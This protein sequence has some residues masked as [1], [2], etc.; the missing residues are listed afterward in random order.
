MTKFYSK[1]SFWLTII[2]AIAVMIFT[3][4]SMC[5]DTAAMITPRSDA[6]KDKI[7]IGYCQDGDYY[8]FDY[9]IFQIGKGLAENGMISSDKL[10]SLRQG[11]SAPTVWSALSDAKSSCLTFV[12]E[13]YFDIASDDF[14][15]LDD[16]EIQNKLADR[17]AEYDIDLMITMGT[18]AGCA[19]RDAC[20]VP[21]M[22]FIASDPIES[23]ITGGEEYSGNNRAWAH[24]STGVEERALTVMKDI[25][26][27]RSVGIVYNNTEEAYIYSGAASV[28]E[29]AKA[30]RIKVMK[31][32]VRDYDDY[33][34][35]A[36]ETY[37]N[38]LLAAH[39]VLADSGIDLYILT[40]TGLE[41][42]D[43]HETLEPFIDKGIPVFSINSTEDVRFGALAAVE[44]FDY[45]NIGRFAAA[46]ISD[47]YNG[48][49]LSEIPQV[50]ET[51]PFLVLNSDTLHR[52]GVKLSLDALISASTIYPKYTGE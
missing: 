12:P 2:P 16:E 5:S 27:A 23:K 31:Q 25:F 39:R 46:N 18:S 7:R 13:A 15:K 44:M 1:R 37:K 43:F 32:F 20:P 4:L 19:V 36:Y 42:D 50:Y 45:E 10:D 29:F 49:S 33:S 52:T 24:V 21:Y 6:V 47:Y 3:A 40:T 38:D 34:S 28:D 14:M 48:V 9:E 35:E 30:N 26:G 8:E 17:I 41:A 51:A 22:N 11:D